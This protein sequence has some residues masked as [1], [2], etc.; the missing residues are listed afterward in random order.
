M[1]NVAVP[2]NISHFITLM[3]VKFYQCLIETL[4]INLQRIS[5]D[6]WWLQTMNWALTEMVFINQSVHLKLPEKVRR[7]LVASFSREASSN[8]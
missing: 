4:Q 6:I 2:T 1:R 3:C 7:H 8:T 5:L